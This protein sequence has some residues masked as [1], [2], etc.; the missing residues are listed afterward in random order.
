MTW[1]N[2]QYAFLHAARDAGAANLFAFSSRADGHPLAFAIDDRAGSYVT[3]A[4]ASASQYIQMDRGAAGLEAI[5][6]LIIPAGHNLDGVEV[7]VRSA[8]DVGITAGVTLLVDS[9]TMDAGIV[10]EDFDASSTQ[11]YVRIDFPNDNFKPQ[12]TQLVY[13]RTRTTTRGPEQGWVDML[14][15]NTLDFPMESRAIASLSLGADQRF[16]ELAYRD[17][18]DSADLA[19]FSELLAEVGTSRPFWVDEPFTD[20]DP[21]WMKLTEDSR[22]LQDPEAPAAT[23]EPKKQIELSMLEHLA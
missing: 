3:F 13:T 12:I 17:V 22:Q 9:V 7:R 14:R 4:A 5:E 11:Q 23:D 16:F 6:R 18:R 21:I 1:Q 10:D 19:V 2:F 15:H 8:T 20:A